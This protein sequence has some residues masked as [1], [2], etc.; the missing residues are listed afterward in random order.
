M[1]DDNAIHIVMDRLEKLENAQK[2]SV[3]SILQEIRLFTKSPNFN[4]E[5]ALD[6]LVNLKIVA[7][8]SKHERSGFF[9]AV[10]FAVQEKMAV[11]EAMFKHYLLALLCDKDHEKVLDAI[12]KVD[13]SLSSSVAAQVPSDSPAPGPVRSR[14]RGRQNVQCYF[15]HRFGHYQRFCYLRNGG[16][17]PKR[18]NFTQSA[19]QK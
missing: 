10:L 19:P 14:G 6:L 18:G 7:K 5:R 16:P 12:A 8:E 11:P 4:K 17:P 1:V 13:K 2:A 15:C 3:E 9:N